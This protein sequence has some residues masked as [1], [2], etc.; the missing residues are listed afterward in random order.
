LLATIDGERL[1]N[2]RIRAGDAREVLE[3]LPAAS[4]DR[5]YILYPDP[6]PKR[7]QWKRRFI[8]AET[9]ATLAR[10][11]KPGGDVRFATDIDDY[12]GWALSRFLVVDDFEWRAENADHWREP[13]T[14]WTSTRYEMKARA[15]GR[16][17]AYLTFRRRASS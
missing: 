15:E 5:V 16:P 7:R 3:A 9:I 17:S 1:A 2:I 11:L 10:V 4:L 6:W 13:W 8:S 12:A 14:G